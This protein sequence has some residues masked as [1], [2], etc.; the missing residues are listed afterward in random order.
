MSKIELIAPSGICS[1]SVEGFA[2]SITDGKVEV[3]EDKVSLFIPHGFWVSGP[4]GISGSRVALIS[5]IV[6]S[7]RSVIEVASDADLADFSALSEAD[8]EKFWK[9]FSAGLSSY[10]AQVTENARQAL[11]DANVAAAKV[12]AD[13]A[14]ADAAEKV[15]ADKAAADAAAK[16]A[17]KAAPAK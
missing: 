13:K 2:V 6:G 12:V 11:E 5:F 15:A 9:G 14:A 3:D 4:S 8:R 10:P 17:A 1:F 7:A 16:A